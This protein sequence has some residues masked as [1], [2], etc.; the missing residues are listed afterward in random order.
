MAATFEEYFRR[1]LVDPANSG[2]TTPAQPPPIS[3]GTPQNGEIIVGPTGPEGPQG[4]P[5]PQ[6][7]KG[8]KG[9]STGVPGPPGPQGPQGVKGDTGNTGST[10]PQGPI[11]NTGS[12]GPTGPTGSTGSAGLPNVVQDEGTPLTVRTALNFVGAGVT[13]T[14]DSANS[15]TNITIAGG[16]G[17]VDPT[18]TKGDIIARG[19]AAPATR[20]GIGADTQVLTADST[21]A[22]GIKWA[23]PGSAPVSSV[24]TRTGAIV[25]ATNDYTAAQVTNAVSTLVSYADPAWITSLPYSKITGTPATGVSSV[26]TRTGA[27]VAASGDYTAAQVTGAVANTR[28][29]IAGTGLTGGGD[30]SADRTL[31]VSITAV[32]TPWTSNI[33]AA[34]FN[35]TNVGNLGIGFSGTPS[36]PLQIISAG[37][38]ITVGQD[39]TNTYTIGRQPG[40]GFLAFVGNQTNNSG[41]VFYINATP[42]ETMRI[43]AVTGYVG[44]G[45]IGPKA[46]LEI[47]G[48]SSA[49]ASG[50]GSGYAALRISNPAAA[51][52]LEIGSY[53]TSPYGMWIQGGNSVTAST[54]QPLILQ[55]LGSNIGIGL[56]A[57]THQLQLSTDDAAKLTT[58]TWATTSGAAVKKNIRDLEGGLEII[59]RLRPIEAEYNGKHKTPD[60][61]R[62]V[63]L[64]AE[65][66]RE[67]L[68]GTVYSREDEEGE[69]LYFNPHEIIFQLILAVKE[70][71][72]EL[73]ELK[74]SA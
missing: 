18:T 47:S 67:V 55:P 16:S 60:G 40:S 11:G 15:R 27:V 65:E 20:L 24:F 69:L 52:I 17:F 7:P 23:A 2:G 14:D 49:P 4:I 53:S 29:V 10:G 57:P 61:Q 64:I 43:Q 51:N 28:Q 33:A 66:V 54:Y 62:L 6:G 36:T 68:P 56:A 30:L 58:T 37:Q 13:V 42:V 44:I 19:T 71:S 38:S 21:Q 41:Y 73:K 8:D 45:G 5:G 26:F 72:K 50:T 59:N 39:S 22:L 25:A 31:N 9:D 12:T 3:G 74:T 46:Q 63:S 35:L 34:T 48:P 32:Q 70:L 1:Y